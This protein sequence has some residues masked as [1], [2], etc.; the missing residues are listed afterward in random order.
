MQ[1][2][3]IAVWDETVDSS[4]ECNQQGSAHYLKPLHRN[5]QP[6]PR[7]GKIRTIK[8]TRNGIRAIEWYLGR[9]RP[10]LNNSSSNCRR[11]PQ[12]ID[13]SWKNSNSRGC[14]HLLSRKRWTVARKITKLILKRIE[15]L[16][17]WNSMQRQKLTIKKN[18][19]PMSLSEL[20]TRRQ[21]SVTI[22]FS[23]ETTR[24]R[25]RGLTW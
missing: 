6:K 3:T 20:A 22:C 4:K 2:R 8:I 23:L 13:K 11:Q 16:T 5:T 7:S 18:L 1:L 25:I 10:N 24:I 14:R 19:L 17:L 9:L 12:L 21:S 15:T